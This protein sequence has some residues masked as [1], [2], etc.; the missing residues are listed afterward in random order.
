MQEHAHRLTLASAAASKFP[1]WRAR[2]DSGKVMSAVEEIADLPEPIPAI[3]IR[4]RRR[5]S[6][7]T[8]CAAGYRARGG[9][10]C[11]RTWLA[12]SPRPIPPRGA[13]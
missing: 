9:P 4:T 3:D 11:A 13:R 10:S 8:S 2:T 7:E 6:A 1:G 5:T 12:R